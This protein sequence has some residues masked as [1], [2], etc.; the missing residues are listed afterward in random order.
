MKTENKKIELED[1]VKIVAN[2]EDHEGYKGQVVEVIGYD[3]MG[4]LTVE[5]SD[6]T[7]WYVGEEEVK[8]V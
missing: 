8:L 4:Y 7:Q 3:D 2:L 6:G 5:S 1:K